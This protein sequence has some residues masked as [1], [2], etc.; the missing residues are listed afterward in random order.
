MDRPPEQYNLSPAGEGL[1][2]RKHID[3]IIRK[4]WILLSVFVI[5]MTFTL[6][7]TFREVP[8]YRAQT[9]LFVNMPSPD[10]S[11]QLIQEAQGTQTVGSD[12]I[13]NQAGIIKSVL[14]ARRVKKSSDLPLSE[15]QIVND[16]NVSFSK[17]SNFMYISFDSQ[18]P[19]LAAKASNAVA[20]AYLEQNIDNLFYSSKELLRLFSSK[21]IISLDSD[22]YTPGADSEAKSSGSRIEAEVIPSIARSPELQS[23]KSERMAAEAELAALSKTYKE[24]HPRIIALNDRIKSINKR[25]QAETERV[26]ENIKVN[27]KGQLYINNAR[28]IDYAQPPSRPIRPDRPKDILNGLFLSAAIGLGL[29][30]LINMLSDTIKNREDLEGALNLPCLGEFPVIKDAQKTAGAGRNFN[31]LDKSPELA[32]AIRTIRTN[33]IFSAAKED[34]KVI[35]LTSTIPQEGKS[36]LS[37]YLAFAFAKSGDR[38]LLID[39]DTRRPSVYKIFGVDNSPGLTNILAEGIPMDLALRETAYDNLYLIT[40]GSR[41]PNSLEILG[42]KTTVELMKTLAGKFD[43]IIIDSPPSHSIH[44]SILLSKVSSVVMLIVKS[45]S[46]SKDVL[47]K[48]RDK[49]VFA[50][51]KVIGV[52]LNFFERGRHG[53]YSDKYYNRYYKGYYGADKNDEDLVDTKTS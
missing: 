8:V 40:S 46:I 6:I 25:F 45:G 41:T 28:I 17:G 23:L 11:S 38:T 26:M 49:F 39:A 24:K 36:L 44:D 47:R 37:S 2:I 5:V 31:T 3:L 42:S 4:R 9:L 34:L 21:D 27:L 1:D 22:K 52:V 7:K 13:A 19:A 29:I 51:A 18:D 20:E 32:D 50:N 33:V 14:I 48:V 10:F 30:Y 35:L 43:K 53:H 12:Y 15:N 16:T